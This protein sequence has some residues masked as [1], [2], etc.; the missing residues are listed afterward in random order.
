MRQFAYLHDT[1][2]FCKPPISFNKWS[3]RKLLA[4]AL[5]A[6]LYM[7]AA[8]VTIAREIVGQKYPGLVSM[9]LCL[10]DAIGDDQVADA[11]QNLILQLSTLDEYIQSGKFSLEDLPIM[12]VRV[13]SPQQMI[14]VLESLGEAAYLLGGFVFPKFSSDDSGHLYFELLQKYNTFSG[15]PFYGMPILETA[16][17][18]YTETR[19]QE[20]L[21][22]K[23]LLDEYHDLVLNVRI[24]ATDFSSLFG[25]RRGPD[26]TAYEILPIS[27]CI[28]D[29]INIFARVESDYIISGP[30]W[31]YFSNGGRVLK[32]QLRQSPFKD[33][34]GTLGKDIRGQLLDK[35]VDGLIR[36]ALLDKENGLMGKTTI[37][38]SH[39]IPIQALYAVSHEEYLDAQHII[40]SSGQ[41]GV[42]RS[43]YTN[44]MNEV[45]P[46][47]NWARKIIL[48]SQA[49]GVL[50]E[51]HN[52]T[53]LLAKDLYL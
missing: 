38:P 14:L 46:H 1:S 31:E 39:L 12:F 33:F 21:A 36:E 34:Y 30:V 19:I 7:P 24:G 44:K 27:S 25:L 20:L 10:E 48:R 17:V 32:P 51:E 35:F 18:I 16:N 3:E 28:A 42:I 13:R 2:I 43:R 5:G 9:V 22:I 50:D 15:G 53:A 40:D 11:E 23:E 29:I 26:V 45:K 4:C 49:Y 37:H 47:Y 41:Q 52:F 8:R 6:T